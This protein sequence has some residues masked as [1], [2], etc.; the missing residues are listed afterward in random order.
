[1]AVIQVVGQLKEES[2][3][4]PLGVLRP[5]PLVQGQ[6]VRLGELHPELLPHQ[7]VWVG[8][9]HLQGHVPV[10]PP[11]G[12]GQLQGQLVGGE[13]LHEKPHTHLLAEGVPNL[14]GPLGGDAPDA[15][16][17]LRVLLQHG[18]GVLPELLNEQPGGGL[19]HPL[20]RPG[21]QVVVDL[22]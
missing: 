1:M 21:G 4:Q 11:Q 12:D 10:G 2:G 7:Q 22:F 9:Q 5:H 15:G 3:L 18:E 8:L 19:A 16:E 20:H 6:G 13:K 14:P 17:L